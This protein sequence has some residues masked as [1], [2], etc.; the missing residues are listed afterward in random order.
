MSSIM[1]ESLL[2]VLHF[3]GV[4]ICHFGKLRGDAA[5]L[6]R[7]ATYVL[8]FKAPSHQP[9][10]VGIMEKKMEATVIIGSQYPNNGESNGKEN[11]K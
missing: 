4:C 9:V 3:T 1:L 2:Q 8:L 11:G 10:Y 6:Q 7:D 5:K